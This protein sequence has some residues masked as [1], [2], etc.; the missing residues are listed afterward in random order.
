MASE[1]PT[2]DESF[3]KLLQQYQRAVDAQD[4]ED[5][6]GAVRDIFALAEEWCDE[7]PSPDFDLTMAAAEREEHADWGGAESTYNQILSLPDVEPLVEYKARSSLVSLCRLLRRESDALDHARHATAAARRA[8]VSIVLSMALRNESQCLIRC[9]HITEAC[10]V[11]ADA[12]SVIDDEKMYNHMNGSILTLR[13]EC[14]IRNGALTDAERDL[15]QASTYLEPL[16]EM[17]IAAGVHS[18]LARRWSITARLYAERGD[19]DKAI[20]AWQ[21]AVSISK[22]VASLPHAESVYTKVTVADMLKGLADALLVC[23]RADDAA[24]AFD[25][26]KEILESVGVPARDAE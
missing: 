5:A 22:H 26:R 23:D 19:R 21:E 1:E 11:I 9:G 18:D 8:D 6:T 20:A 24:T 25:E 15:E 13:A 3:G 14:A 2:P 12:I 10:N 7:N 16:A 4:F 17:E